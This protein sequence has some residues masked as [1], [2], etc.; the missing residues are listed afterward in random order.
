MMA[1]MIR[2]DPAK[3]RDAT[4]IAWVVALVHSRRKGDYVSAA[5]AHE[6]LVRRGVLVKFTSGRKAVAHGR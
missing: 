1:A 6:E 5:A 4:I 2:S 3:D